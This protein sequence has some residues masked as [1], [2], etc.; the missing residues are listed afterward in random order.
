MLSEEVPGVYDGD[1]SSEQVGMRLHTGT[2]V[3]KS[4]H[5]TMIPKT[6]LVCPTTVS[7]LE[8]KLNDT[9]K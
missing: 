6:S 8:E 7:G 3:G 1:T 9:H 2:A 5:K 4:S